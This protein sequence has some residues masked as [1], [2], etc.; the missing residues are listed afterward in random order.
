M[1]GSRDNARL[2]QRRCAICQNVGESSPLYHLAWLRGIPF[3]QQ[4]RFRIDYKGEDIGT[5]VPDL[6][7]YSAVV[8][9]TK[10]IDRITDHEVGRMLNYL[11]VTKRPVGAHPQFQV[12]ETAM[13]KSGQHHIAQPPSLILNRVHPR[14]SAFIRGCC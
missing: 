1:L 6:I 14:S 13:A 9:D 10:T 5:F 11:K 2:L 4:P 3:A 7:T 8:I 12:C